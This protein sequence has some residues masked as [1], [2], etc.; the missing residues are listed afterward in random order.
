MGPCPFAVHPAVPTTA[1]TR[2]EISGGAC[3]SLVARLTRPHAYFPN[4]YQVL[5]A[6]RRGRRSLTSRRCALRRASRR[7]PSSRPWALSTQTT[8]KPC[9]APSAQRRASTCS[10]A[11]RACDAA[12]SSGHVSRLNRARPFAVQGRVR[13]PRARVVHR[14]AVQPA[15]A[16][17]GQP[18]QPAGVPGRQPYQRHLV[19]AWYVPPEASRAVKT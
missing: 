14:A 12:L 16:P 6:R 8:R 10:G 3:N 11:P 17:P 1:G 7:A 9:P 15:P 18:H 19:P 13:Q 5:A 2:L 4:V